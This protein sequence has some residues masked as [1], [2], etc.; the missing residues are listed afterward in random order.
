M[1]TPLGVVLQV[2]TTLSACLAVI[3]EATMATC[4]PPETHR[5]KA[6]GLSSETGE[7]GNCRRQLGTC[8]QQV[9]PCGANTAKKLTLDLLSPGRLAGMVGSHFLNSATQLDSTIC[10]QACGQ[11]TVAA[12]ALCTGRCPLHGHQKIKNMAE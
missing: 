11:T 7:I 1:S 9:K 5:E 4:K 8:A 3:S 10:S 6:D 2:R 12:R